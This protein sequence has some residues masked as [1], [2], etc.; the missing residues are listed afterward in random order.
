M[1]LVQPK[2]QGR[3]GERTWRSEGPPIPTKSVV[4]TLPSESG[5]SSS[6]HHVAHFPSYKKSYQGEMAS[7][8]TAF[9]DQTSKDIEPFVQGVISALVEASKSS[10]AF[11]EDSEYQ[12]LATFPKFRSSMAEFSKKVLGLG[13]RLVESKT[14]DTEDDVPQ[15]TSLTDVNDADDE[16]ERVADVIDVLMERVVR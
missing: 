7:G 15:L 13:Q 4:S 6:L 2:F 5:S 1:K 3:W 9:V 10:A 11:P 12:Y 16:Y 14:A 8:S